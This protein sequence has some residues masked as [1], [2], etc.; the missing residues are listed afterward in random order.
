MDRIGK[1]LLR[2]SKEAIAREGKDETFKRRDL[3]SLLLKANMSTNIAESQR[4]SDA[5]VLARELASFWRSRA[6]LLT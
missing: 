4:M 2:E 5:D 6:N 3:L 1:Q